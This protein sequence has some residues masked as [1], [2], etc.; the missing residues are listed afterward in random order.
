MEYVDGTPLSDLIGKGLPLTRIFALAIPLTDAISAAHQKGITHRDLKPANVMVTSD[1]RV[2]V[3]DFGLA[4]L[5]E[6]PATEMAVL[7]VPPDTLTEEG[8]IV[9]TVA[10][11][12]P[13]QAEGNPVD[14]RTDVFSLGVLLYEMAT[15]E[16]P[17]PGDTKLSVL[18][19]IVKDT[20]R[21]VTDLNP[22]LPREFA[23]VVKRC[24]AKARE[25]RYQTAVDLRNELEEVRAELESGAIS[26]AATPAATRT[27]LAKR[28]AIASIGIVALLL[29]GALA[30]FILRRDVLHRDAS[31]PPTP[32]YRQMTFVGDATDPAISRDGKFLAYITGTASP[33]QKLMVQDLSGGQALQVF[34]GKGLLHPVWSNDGAEMLVTTITEPGSPAVAWIVP[35]LGGP[36]RS[37]GTPLLFIGKSWSP[38]GARFAG[39]NT[40]TKR[41]FV[42]EKRTG[43]V[44]VLPLTGSFAFMQAIDWSPLGDLLLFETLDEN[45]R[46]AIWTIRVDGSG[47]EKLVE[48]ATSLSSPRWSSKGDAI[49]YLRGGALLRLPVSRRTRTATGSPEA[50]LTGLQTGGFTISDDGQQLA[51]TRS[52]GHSNLW[53]A[54]TK[55]APDGDK[56]MKQ[57]TSGTASDADPSIAPDGRHVALSRFDGNR[58]NIF[59]MP[60]E[61]GTPQQITFLNSLNL[62]AVWSPDGR[63]I[64]FAST[65]GGQ[66]YVWQV[67]ATGGTPRALEQ[68]RVSTNSFKLAWAPSSQILYQ[69]PG[70]RNFQ[71]LNPV[72]GEHRPLVG[73]SSIGWI[74]EAHASPD[75]NQVA[76]YWNRR[77]SDNGLWV[78]PIQKPSDARL[79]A[80]DGDSSGTVNQSVDASTLRG[81]EVTLVA[82]VKTNVDGPGNQGQCWLR[83]DRPN[84]KRGFVEDMEDR[85]I[86]SRVWSEVTIAG[87][88]DD[89]AEGV[90][91]GCLLKG[92]GQMWVDDIQLRRKT[93][94]GQ[95]EAV[96]IKNP[97]FEEGDD[98]MRP[99]GWNVVGPGDT[100]QLT[101]AKPYKDHRS[102][103]IKSAHVNGHFYP[104][105]WSSDGKYV[106]A[107]EPNRLKEVMMIR[108]D[109][110]EVRPLIDLPIPQG[111]SI[112]N[113]AIT[114]DGHRVVY[115]VY[116]SQSD[117]WIVQNF[118]RTR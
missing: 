17:F 88:V 31:L 116:Q 45:E 40:G 72:T 107:I 30:L 96:A 78:I 104:I 69:E 86:H 62:G 33:Q 74:L 71:V 52:V 20:P 60:V 77:G 26:P 73:N 35:R 99:A 39:F 63:T 50:V 105:G 11:M 14:S 108:A 65:E 9:G 100:F 46:H 10:Y 110:A 44:T 113:L 114:P 101:D 13:E 4:K 28:I 93:P 25:R 84:G 34:E 117:V 6:A 75:G 115:G 29:I 89:D 90:A 41:I 76:V 37:V 92:I 23:R 94:G 80:A 106:Y 58:A 21:S 18:S 98:R 54:S 82:H 109:G 83:V 112:N 91:F 87:R 12:S 61:G 68:T 19:A 67:G 43:R 55:L 53:L 51:C 49:Y 2:K 38:D 57:L 7:G 102:L 42:V 48:D 111:F 64:A 66:Q 36:A 22:A 1:G 97:S 8:R 32:V 103:A 15:G 47:Q 5:M 59:V 118:D 81:R 79:L 24:L 3:L 16:R 70:N 95:W 85:P 56:K 27:R